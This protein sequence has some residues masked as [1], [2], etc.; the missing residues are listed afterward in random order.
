MSR[1]MDE[2]KRRVDSQGITVYR[3]SQMTGINKVTLYR[4]WNGK[5]DP[6]ISTVEKI[7]AALRLGVKKELK[8]K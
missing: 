5:A 4:I 6:R 2:L 8:P 7:A 1:I 3:L